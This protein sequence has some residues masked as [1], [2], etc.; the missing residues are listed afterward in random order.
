MTTR[1]LSFKGP[2]QLAVAAGATSPNPGINGV[3]IW[4]TTANAL[5]VWD[6]NS[7]ELAGGGMA[8]TEDT[9]FRP[10]DFNAPWGFYAF[11]AG[12]SNV[13]NIG[14]IAYTAGTPSGVAPSGTSNTML[15]QTGCTSFTSDATAYSA[16]G[17][18]NAQCP[19]RR[20]TVTYG[21]FIFET[22]SGFAPT[23]SGTMF[24]GLQSGGLVY[25]DTPPAT[26][27]AIGIG[28]M[29]GDNLATGFRIYFGNGTSIDTSIWVSRPAGTRNDPF[30]KLYIRVPGGGSIAKMWL[31]D[32]GI[33]EYP[34]GVTVLDGYEMD[35]STLPITT[36]LET[37]TSIGNVASGGIQ[38]VNF[39][40]QKLRYWNAPQVYPEAAANIAGNAGTADTLLT[41]RNIQGIPFD[42]STNIDVVSIGAVA[43]ASPTLNQLWIQTA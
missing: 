16:C 13:G 31:I 27:A 4:S 21:G 24:M 6:G 43:P 3:Q 1:Q 37:V 18:W 22:L 33:A 35:I 8:S 17:V 2:P 10:V 38:V 15:G 32:Y 7:W 11:T 40:Y 5:V 42:G 23:N 25:N 26:T 9:V 28:G 36:L 12:G 39:V 29:P 19:V 20:G 14:P 34:D 30:Y 41:P